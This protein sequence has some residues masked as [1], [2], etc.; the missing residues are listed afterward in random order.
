MKYADVAKCFDRVLAILY[1]ITC[2]SVLGIYFLTYYFLNNYGEILTAL[3][4]EYLMVYADLKLIDFGFLV[5]LSACWLLSYFKGSSMRS[6]AF[7]MFYLILLM[8]FAYLATV[9]I[10]FIDEFLLYNPISSDITLYKM[11]TILN[12][13][14]YYCYFDLLGFASISF[15]SICVC[16]VL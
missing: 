16:F 9:N 15:L 2:F 13:I 14:K 6:V 12:I 4:Y 11:N 3:M 5:L 8:V 7:L 10:R 1:G